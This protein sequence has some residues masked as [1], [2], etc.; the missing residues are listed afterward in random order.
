MENIVKNILILLIGLFLL[1]CNS[2]S[3]KS[4]DQHWKDGK[5]YRTEAKLMESIT[6]FKSIIK[7]YPL[8]ELSAQAQFQIA[9]IYLNDVKDFEFAIEEFQK[10]VSIYPNHEVAKKSLFMIAYV[11]NNYLDAYSDAIIYY[12]MFKDKYSV[13][14]IMP[15]MIMKWKKKVGDIIAK[16][17]IL[18]EIS[19]D[20]INM[21]VSAPTSGRVLEIIPKI[22]DIVSFGDTIARIGDELIPSVEYELEGLKVFQSTIDSLNSLVNKKSNI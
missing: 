14:V 20:K 7:N 5:K 13:D 21:K 2:S 22:N 4:A 11:Y 16:D 15:P 17:E 12:N 18:L 10:V 1:S 9:D 8:H 19:I 6:S 3:N